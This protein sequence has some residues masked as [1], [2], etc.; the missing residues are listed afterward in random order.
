[1]PSWYEYWMEPPPEPSP[2]LE[3]WKSRIKGGW[4]PNRR[5]QGMGY[6]E[7]SHFFKIYYWE[8]LNVIAPLLRSL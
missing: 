2:S 6:E 1:M 8:Y 7:A 3:K 4:R 5:I